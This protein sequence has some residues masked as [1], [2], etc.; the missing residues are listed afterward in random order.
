[1]R[2]PSRT[3]DP[4]KALNVGILVSAST[5]KWIRELSKELGVGIGAIV[6]LFVEY[7]RENRNVRWDAL[8]NRTTLSWGVPRKIQ[9][10]GADVRPLKPTPVRLKLVDQ[11][12]EMPVQVSPEDEAAEIEALIR[13]FS[14]AGP[15]SILDEPWISKPAI[16]LARKPTQRF[17]DTPDGSATLVGVVAPLDVE[18]PAEAAAVVVAGAPEA[19]IEAPDGWALIKAWAAEEHEANLV[20]LLHMLRHPGDFLDEEISKPILDPEEDARWAA[21]LAEREMIYANWEQI[22][23]N[24]REYI[25]SAQEIRDE[26]HS[27]RLRESHSKEISLREQELS[28]FLA[29][30]RASQ[31][32]NF[33]KHLTSDSKPD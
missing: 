6:G 31:R 27:R 26:S 23:V 16:K 12:P 22:V 24:T 11:P 25:R 10:R 30:I 4:Q 17:C 29:K 32:K 20:Q 14:V 3:D 15:H 5:E 28:G 8:H 2:R 13:E 1:M 21:A 9:L 19:T 7:S 33:R 18:K